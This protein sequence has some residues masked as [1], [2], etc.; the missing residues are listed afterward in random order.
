MCSTE[1]N[2]ERDK[3]D[4]IFSGVQLQRVFEVERTTVICL[5]LWS[6]MI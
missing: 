2:I 6:G 4:D 1:S 3:H 5:N